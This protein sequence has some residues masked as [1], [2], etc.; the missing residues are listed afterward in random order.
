MT[1]D[2]LLAN[3]FKTQSTAIQ[4]VI[5]RTCIIDFGVI[6]EILGENIVKVGIAV[7]DSVE[8]IQ[9]L[10]C[11]LISPCSASLAINIEPNV[12]DKVLII[13]PRHYNPD[14]FKVPEEDEDLAPIIDDTCQGY[15]RLSA[16]AILMNQ[17]NYEKHRKNINVS[18]DG[19]LSVRLPYDDDDNA[20]IITAQTDEDGKMSLDIAKDSDE[21]DADLITMTV[22]QDGNANLLL[23]QGDTSAVNVLSEGKL[24][25]LV[26]ED[27]N[28]I[29]FDL[30]DTDGQ[31][32]VISTY[33]TSVTTDKDNKLTVDNGKATVK[34]DDSG[35]VEI[36]AQGKYKI[37]NGSTDLKDVIDGL[38]KELENLTTVGSPATQATSPASKGT[39]A[40]WRSGKLSQL[41]N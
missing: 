39:I 10:T 32:T 28:K 19:V 12:G 41:F 13:S 18:A 27:K 11:T 33:G 26:G 38:A 14:M 22:D 20:N 5:K 17:F 34:I 31:T 3:I 1:Q 21:D 24:E 4:Q 25:Y 40:T 37:K 23:H 36:D 9:I 30:S 16:L 7:A 15:T 8:D 6:T 29:T 35:N 2:D